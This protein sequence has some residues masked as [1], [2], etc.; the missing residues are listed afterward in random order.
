MNEQIY[1]HFSKTVDDYDTVA[2]KVVFKNKEL[3]Y[4][5]INAIPFNSEKKLEV[6]D[7]GSGTGHGMLL[8]LKKFANAKVTGVDFSH[9][10]ILKSKKNLNKLLRRATLVEANFNEK[11]INQKYDA[12]VSSVAI[13]NSIHEQKRVLF[14]KIFNSLNKDGVFINGDF[15]EGESSE[16]NEH[17]KNIYK[18][19]LEKNLKGHELKVWLKHAFEEDLPMRLSEQFKILREIGFKD[20][21]LI[22]QFNNEAIYVARK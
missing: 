16:I 11:E 21:K 10:M 19:Y 15:I 9:R 3:H 1:I 8:T 6:L 17:Y 7:L 2:E 14:K 18:D 4:V 22:W 12:I 20:I 5:L 13:H